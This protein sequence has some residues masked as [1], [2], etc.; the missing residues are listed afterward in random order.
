MPPDLYY[1][2]SAVAAGLGLVAT[3]GV[4]YFGAVVVSRV[5]DAETRRRARASSYRARRRTP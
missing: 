1:A 2:L 4:V 3:V 5:W